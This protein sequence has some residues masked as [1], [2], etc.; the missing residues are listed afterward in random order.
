MYRPHIVSRLLP[1][2]LYITDVNKISKN[3][4]KCIFRVT[5]RGPNA[6]LIIIHINIVLIRQYNHR[7][8]KIL[9]LKRLGTSSSSGRSQ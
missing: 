1:H 4:I 6:L 5:R 9:N 2:E 8:Y 7:H 3:L